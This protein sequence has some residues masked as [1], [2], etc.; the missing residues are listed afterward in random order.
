MV[1]LLVSITFL[2]TSETPIITKHPPTSKIGEKDSCK[3]AIP[4]TIAKIGTKLIKIEALA[5]P[6]A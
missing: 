2:L 4:K 6:T 5:A 1:H 3:K